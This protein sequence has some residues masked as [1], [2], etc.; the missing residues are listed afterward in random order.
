ME[1]RFLNLAA[2]ILCILLVGTPVF[3]IPVSY[4]TAS[5]QTT[6]WQELATYEDG[7]E[8]SEYGVF[9]SVDG[10]AWGQDTN[11]FVGQDV[12]FMFNMHKENVGTHYADHL[13]A[14]MDWGQDGLFDDAD[15]IAYG[16]QE[17]AT[18][19]TGNFG[20]R[21]TPIVPDYTFTTGTFTLTEDYVGD[22]YLRSRITCSHSL[23]DSM[24][25]AWGDQWDISEADYQAGFS[26]TGW[27]H[28]GEVEEWQI[29]VNSAAPVPEPAT[30]VLLSMG[31]AGFAAFRRKNRK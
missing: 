30:M 21:K 18:N 12:N 22:L 19:E 31:L 16:Y 4:G 28:Q 15:E 13:K 3:A 24:G 17:L 23:A 2:F 25:Y 5:H 10:G 11:L 9:W 8:I 1:K 27:L 6:A 14:W 26:A 20:S 29:T 7:S